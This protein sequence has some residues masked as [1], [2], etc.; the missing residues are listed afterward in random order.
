MW[1]RVGDDHQICQVSTHGL[2]RSVKG[3]FGGERDGGHSSQERTVAPDTR[4]CHRHGRAVQGCHG[5]F[6]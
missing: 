1:P 4:G 5:P 3:V 2:R 6:E